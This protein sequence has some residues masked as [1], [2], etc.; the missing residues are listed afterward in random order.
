[1]TMHVPPAPL[2]AVLGIVG[3]TGPESTVDYYRLLLA[4][5]H[6]RGCAANPHLFLHS[7]DNFRLLALASAG[8]WAGMAT[9]LADAFA[10]LERA[11]AQIGL[12]AAN[13]PHVVFD[14]VAARTT[15]PLV[16]IVEA[17]CA[18][19]R[20]R[21]LRR[22]ALLGTRFT[23]TGGFY[24]P[25]ATRHGIEL[26][27]PTPDDLAYVHHVYVDEMI[28]GQFRP[29]SRDGVLAVIERLR[30]DTGV[31][32]A[33]L[34]GTELPI[35]LRGAPEPLPLLDTTRIHVEA[36]VEAALAAGPA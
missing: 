3:G 6:E 20:A 19:V 24:P 14:E 10:P 16:S 27:V 18:A 31:E 30:R 21:G 12:I 13:T 7:V 17:T 33:I 11:G 25:V 28:P 1:M 35:L 15:L 8:D 26:V 23:M 36:A 32:A 2:P 5:F 22:V 29:E 4:R 9:Y 34:G